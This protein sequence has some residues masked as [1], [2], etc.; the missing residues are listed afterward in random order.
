MRFESRR[1]M[2][3]LLLFISITGLVVSFG[4]NVLCAGELP[5]THR[6][7]TVGHEHTSLRLMD[8]SCPCAPSSP[9]SS[10]DHFC[11]GDCGCS[12]HAPL[13]SASI[14][15]IRSRTFTHLYHPELTRHIP[16][17]YISLFVPP[18]VPIV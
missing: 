12:C 7:A 1:I 13:L 16:V 10:G 18:D 8:S 9:D 11:D 14:T 15:L 5:G 4:E 6:T 3:L 17:V 2:A